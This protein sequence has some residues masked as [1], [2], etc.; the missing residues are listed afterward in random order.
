[1]GRACVH[2]YNVKI[3]DTNDE[4]NGINHMLEQ[5]SEQV[6]HSR[7]GKEMY[8]VNQ[9]TVPLITYSFR[10]EEICLDTISRRCLTVNFN[11]PK[12]DL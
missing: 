11:Q 8:I 1:M 3:N 9:I 7:S 10:S 5:M 4:N 6:V 12:D 2:A